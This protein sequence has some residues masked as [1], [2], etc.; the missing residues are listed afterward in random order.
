MERE[1]APA[2]PIIHLNREVAWW[3]QDMPKTP[4]NRANS[5]P[6]CENCVFWRGVQGDGHRHCKR[7]SPG[8]VSGWSLTSWDDWCGRHKTTLAY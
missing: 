4:G 5:V 1:D 8:L 2:D 6:R 7:S 3:E